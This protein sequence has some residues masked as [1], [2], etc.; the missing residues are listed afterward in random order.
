MIQLWRSRRLLGKEHAALDPTMR[1]FRD[2]AAEAQKSRL[3]QMAA[4]LSYRTI[5]GLIPVLVVALVLVKAF[6]GPDE[7][8]QLLKDATRFAGL[9][10]IFVQSGPGEFSAGGRPSVES[11][12]PAEDPATLVGP[13]IP[14]DLAERLAADAPELDAWVNALVVR[15]QSNIHLGAVGMV[16]FATL[17][18]AA[19]GMLVEIERAFNQIFRVPRGRSWVRRVT[20]YW[21]LLTLGTIGLAAT[22]YVGAKFQDWAG[23]LVEARGWEIGSGALT[24]AILGFAVT[25]AI[26]TLLLTVVYE[27]VPNT[28]VRPLP[29]LAGAIIAAVLWE[30]GKWGFAEYL[31][32]SN[33]Y[34]R[35]Y[36]SLAL[37]PLFL[38]W[39]YVTWFIV[40]FG[41][42]VTYQLQYGLKNRVAQPLSES[43]P[44]MVDPSA[45]VVVMGALARAFQTGRTRTAAELA[46]D[47]QLSEGVVAM[48]LGAM[49]ERGLAH[50]V[51]RSDQPDAAPAY[52]LARPP[53][54]I[55][56][57]RVM[58]IGFDLAGISAPTPAGVS[59]RTQVRDHFRKALIDAAKGQTLASLIGLPA[60]SG[61]PANTPETA[62][63]AVAAKTPA[64][65]T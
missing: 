35:L 11:T 25:V 1:A 43:G 42:A 39:V 7:Q 24:A 9:H 17:V 58:E 8:A 62:G 54:A 37:V 65:A 59:G 38:F 6:T 63:P 29:A 26:S 52:A 32:Y 56:A 12:P 61:Q 19:L 60:G 55:P 50:R 2:A 16:G 21:T 31:K 48:V 15:A 5:F 45:S 22:F 28:K 53:D 46:A 20:N 41:L 4:A 40:L 10:K 30:A 36:G 64:A 51:D 27:T 23:R 47:T 34:A 13:P 14:P 33:S 3:P 18:Y 44:S 57:D 49:S